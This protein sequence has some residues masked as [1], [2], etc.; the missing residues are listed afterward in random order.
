M[1]D[2]SFDD[3]RRRH[4]VAAVDRVELGSIFR[5][6]VRIATVDIGQHRRFPVQDDANAKMIH[7]FAG[8]RIRS[9]D[10]HFVHILKKKK[11]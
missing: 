8:D 5:F 4:V 10:D 6:G 9:S 7:Q 3:F 1:L 11:A 2:D